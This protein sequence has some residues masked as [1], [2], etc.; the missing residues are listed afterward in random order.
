MTI[1]ELMKH[2]FTEEEMAEAVNIVKI[3]QNEGFDR[4]SV[5]LD[6]QD[7]KDGYFVPIKA[8]KSS[9]GYGYDYYIISDGR[10]IDFA[11]DK[12]PFFE[13]FCRQD[14]GSTPVS[15]DCLLYY[16]M[17][18]LLDDD[19][20]DNCETVSYVLYYGFCFRA[21]IEHKTE[22][23]KLEPIYGY[24]SAMGLDGVLDI[25]KHGKYDFIRITCPACKHSFMFDITAVPVGARYEKPC[26]YCKMLLN[27]KRID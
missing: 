10:V 7:I 11:K 1:E 3:L 25:S 5:R 4:A 24:G 21:T 13:R 2:N 19:Q 18:I 12:M 26:P 27:R 20:R 8:I 15:F 6:E 14:Y 17:D 16:L 22:R 23:F 9:T